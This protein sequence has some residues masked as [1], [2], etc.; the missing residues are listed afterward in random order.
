M[1][2]PAL[3]VSESVGYVDQFSEEIR[4][5]D[6]VQSVGLWPS[7]LYIAKVS[8]ITL[9]TGNTV[10]NGIEIVYDITNDDAQTAMHGNRTGIGH[11]YCLTGD[12]LFVGFFGAMDDN[13]NKPTLRGIGFLIFDKATGALSNFGPFPSTDQPN[14]KGFA[15]LGHVVGFS[16]SIAGNGNIGTLA[17]YKSLPGYTGKARSSN[18]EDSKSLKEGTLAI[19]IRDFTLTFK[20][21]TVEISL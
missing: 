14:V 19:T 21:C 13:V 20:L 7:S 3:V 18:T 12:Q 16:G 17:I 10:V 15:S 5:F 6:D 9:F 8:K 11:S 2:L 1:L 4:T